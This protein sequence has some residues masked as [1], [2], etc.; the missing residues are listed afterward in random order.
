[1]INFIKW[2]WKN[3]FAIA[4]AIAAVVAM[5]AHILTVTQGC[6]NMITILFI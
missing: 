1:M 5:N 6:Y 4:I 2:N 3:L